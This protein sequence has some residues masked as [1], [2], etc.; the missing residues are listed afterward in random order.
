MAA[1][2]SPGRNVCRPRCAQLTGPGCAGNNYYTINPLIQSGCSCVKAPWRHVACLLALTR[3]APPRPTSAARS[4]AQAEGRR[5]WTATQLLTRNGTA[6]PYLQPNHTSSLSGVARRG[7][8]LTRLRS[9]A[10][11]SLLLLGRPQARPLSPR[12]A[13]RPGGYSDNAPD[14]Y[15]RPRPTS[16]LGTAADR[17]GG[18]GRAGMNWISHN[19]ANPI[20]V[21]RDRLEFGHTSHT[22]CVT[23]GAT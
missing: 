21:L 3:P 14:L 15:N 7:W 10:P 20:A 19:S 13:P 6:V 22:T 18:W 16:R 11:C 9:Q 5:V 2:R 12:L 8:A 1:G 23:P 4:R 17:G